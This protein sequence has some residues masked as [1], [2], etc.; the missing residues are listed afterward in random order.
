MVCKVERKI[1]AIVLFIIKLV[2]RYYKNVKIVQLI[3]NHKVGIVK[4][5]A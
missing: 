3:N 2:I 5:M 1:L 4:N